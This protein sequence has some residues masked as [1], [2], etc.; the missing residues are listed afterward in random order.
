MN[1]SGVPSNTSYKLDTAGAQVRLTDEQLQLQSFP[2]LNIKKPYQNE[3][4]QRALME[5]C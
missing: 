5:T 1:T 3:N 2:K 4:I